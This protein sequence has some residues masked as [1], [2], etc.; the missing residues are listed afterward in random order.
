MLYL[1]EQGQK[2][3]T[4]K[5]MAKVVVQWTEKKEKK[6]KPDTPIPITIFF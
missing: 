2:G 4:E 3:L 6:K 5:E 1:T